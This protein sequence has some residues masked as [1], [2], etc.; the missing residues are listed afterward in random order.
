[1]LKV[2]RDVMPSCACRVAAST[3]SSA[4]ASAAALRSAD[5]QLYGNINRSFEPPSLA[6]LTSGGALP[7]APL[8]EQRATTFEIGSRGQA[9]FIAWDIS[10]Y[11]S[12][13]ENEFLD[14]GVPG[15]NGFV[16]FTANA[17][18]TIHQGVEL[19]LDL[20]RA[21]LEARA[22]AFRCAGRTPSTISA[23]MVTRLMA[24]TSSPAFRAICSSSEAR[25]EQKDSWYVSA[26]LRWVFDGPWADFANTERAPGY[27]LVGLTA[28]VDGPASAVRIGRE[29]VR[30]GVHLQR[31][32]QRQPVARARRDLHARVGRAVYG[33]ITG[34]V[35]SE[36]KGEQHHG[37]P[38][39]LGRWSMSK[40]QWLALIGGISL[41]IWGLSG[42]AHIVMVLF[43]PQQAEFMP[44][45]RAV[46]MAGARR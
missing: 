35:L 6:D 39:K 26:N 43:G 16:S 3:N 40:H 29:P 9:D 27:E 7:F 12:E 15:T 22:K 4:L 13:V 11:R 24:T 30:H 18:R 2:I 1:M 17:D 45:M 20:S 19:G 32:H 23:S 42:L 33:G 25:F 36:G 37:K 41:F 44:P 10:L 46:E 21:G 31:R 28:G 8:K 5:I 34:A 38:S 14:F